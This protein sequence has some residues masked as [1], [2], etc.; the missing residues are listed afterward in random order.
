VGDRSGGLNKKC[1]HRRHENDL[2]SHDRGGPHPLRRKKEREAQSRS[3]DA[4]NNGREGPLKM[5]LKHGIQ[6]LTIAC[7]TWEGKKANGCRKALEGR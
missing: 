4:L 7:E 6:A 5:M 3:R 1:N 2:I